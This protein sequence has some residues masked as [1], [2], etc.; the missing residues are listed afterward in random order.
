MTTHTLAFRCVDL[1]D[2]ADIE[3]LQRMTERSREISFDTFARHVDWKPLA[4]DMGYA[5]KPGE[6]GIRLGQDRLV[7]FRVST[8]RGE[9]VYYMV[10][11]S[12]EF[13]FRAQ[14]PRKTIRPSSPWSG[15]CTPYTTPLG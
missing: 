12:I 11:S 13:V 8:W 3:E 2:P 6:K 1:T 4:R 14:S 7:S 9:R 10:H 15:A 5:V